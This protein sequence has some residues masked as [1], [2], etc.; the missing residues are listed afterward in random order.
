MGWVRALGKRNK[1]YFILLYHGSKETYKGIC[2]YCS[3]SNSSFEST[4]LGHCKATT[5]I[6]NSSCYSSTTHNTR[7]PGI[8]RWR[9]WPQSKI[10]VMPM[11]G[12]WTEEWGFWQVWLRRDKWEVRTSAV[13][14]S[15]WTSLRRHLINHQIVLWQWLLKCSWSRNASCRALEKTQPMGFMAPSRDTGIQCK[16]SAFVNTTVFKKGWGE[17]CWH[18]SI[19]WQDR[20]SNW[21]S[22]SGSHCHGCGACSESMDAEAMTIEELQKLMVW[23]ETMCP[24]DMLMMPIED[25]ETLKFHTGE[26]QADTEHM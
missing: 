16:Q 15:Q 8:C 3:C 14:A 26:G 9:N 13:R 22:C 12:I 24:D 1:F 4:T 6:K 11:V 19:G 18:V 25:L 5:G 23:S 10:Q 20:N 7:K 2:G 21:V 17:I